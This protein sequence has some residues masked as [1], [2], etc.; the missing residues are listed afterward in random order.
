MGK[1]YY[2]AKSINFSIVRSGPYVRD[3]RGIQAITTRG[4]GSRNYNTNIFAPIRVKDLNWKTAKEINHIAIRGDEASH[5]KPSSIIKSILREKSLLPK[6]VSVSNRYLAL[7]D[8]VQKELVLPNL[9]KP[10]GAE[11]IVDMI[12]SRR[13]KVVEAAY[14]Q[15]SYVKLEDIANDKL[16]LLSPAEKQWLD[17]TA[18]NI[19]PLVHSIYEKQCHSDTTLT[20][21]QF[22]YRGNHPVSAMIFSRTR[23]GEILPLRNGFIPT[24]V[25][26]HQRFASSLPWFPD[27]PALQSAMWPKDMTVEELKKLQEDL[28]NSHDHQILMPYTVVERASGVD[29][30]RATNICL[31]PRFKPTFEKIASEFRRSTEIEGL[32]TDF[33]FY[34]NTIAK[35]IEDG[36]FNGWLKADMAQSNKG[37]LFLTFFPHESYWPDNIK[38]P[39]SLEFGI[40]DREP[41]SKREEDKTEKVELI[42]TYSTSG[43]LRAYVSAEPAGHDYPTIDV[44][45]VKDHRT[46]VPLDVLVAT[47]IAYKDLLKTIFHPEDYGRITINAMT[48]F[49]VGHEISH[50]NEGNRRD[51]VMKDGKT[52]GA[53]FGQLWG[54]V[55][56][57]GADMGSLVKL[58]EMCDSGEIEKDEKFGA[59]S[60]A[61]FR[62]IAALPPT[63]ERMLSDDYIFIAPHVGGTMLFLGYLFS[64]NEQIV[65][66]GEYNQIII[67]YAKLEERISSLNQILIDFGLKGSPEEF[68]AFYRQQ[69]GAIPDEFA[70]KAR[71]ITATH[72]HK[73][74][75]RR[76][77]DD[78]FM[79]Y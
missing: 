19:A 1:I 60:F 41:I 30:Y 40:R 22:V 77:H 53:I 31:H 54:A 39:F 61:V 56:E 6:G 63:K 65:R 58:K 23:V 13:R 34:I 42:W 3:L 32:D 8:K 29:P 71:Q 24:D 12:E 74:F 47:S 38:M 50:G 4:F 37:K 21:N 46:V 2:G 57:P 76:P 26:E 33:A 70:D 16:S 36:D 9:G 62:A 59:Y 35:A 52:M 67:D 75:V 45:G 44:Y 73:T 55:A 79:R 48:E 15:M 5:V 78:A 68:L 27:K 43:F 17:F 69:V 72:N 20:S 10:T 14:A 51:S 49:T 64:R 25:P 7:Y 11:Q 66:F 18:K 28:Q